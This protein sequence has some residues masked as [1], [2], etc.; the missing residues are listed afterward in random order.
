MLSLLNKHKKQTNQ[1]YLYSS[2]SQ[3]I[4][5][6]E[7][8]GNFLSIHLKRGSLPSPSKLSW[9]S[10]FEPSLLC[11][12]SSRPVYTRWPANGLWKCCS[13][14]LYYLLTFKMLF[15]LLSVSSQD[16]LLPCWKWHQS[17]I[18][19]KLQFLD[20]TLYRKGERN[21]QRILYFAK[22]TILQRNTT[23]IHFLSPRQRQA[24]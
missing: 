23:C 4:T 11:C 6:L 17:R 14:T 3:K 22:E 1:S 5:T 13:W 21:N 20:T 10:L 8:E 18:Q 24:K 19:I 12:W 9:N 2:W 7:P 16:Q 15:L